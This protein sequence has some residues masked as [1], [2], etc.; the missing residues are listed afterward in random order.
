MSVEQFAESFKD[1]FK[2]EIK[3]IMEDS[4]VE[5]MDEILLDMFYEPDED[6]SPIARR[7]KAWY[8]HIHEY[9]ALN[10][11]NWDDRIVI[12]GFSGEPARF[13]RDMDARCWY[14]IN[15]PE[16]TYPTVSELELTYGYMTMASDTAWD[17]DNHDDRDFVHGV[18]GIVMSVTW[19]E[20]AELWMGVTEDSTNYYDSLLQIGAP[21]SPEFSEDWDRS[22][23]YSF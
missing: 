22:V 13:C 2:T 5:S 11:L 18:T 4:I 23:E 19:D 7:S 15:N 20:E 21:W 17:D 16:E 8:D 14:N 10:E 3:Q 9:P 6:V 1:R 12:D